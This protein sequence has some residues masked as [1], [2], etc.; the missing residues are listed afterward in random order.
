[1]LPCFLIAWTWAWAYL[2]HCLPRCGTN[3]QY[4]RKISL[5]PGNVSQMNGD[6]PGAE[7]P[8][9]SLIARLLPAMSATVGAGLLAAAIAACGSSASTSQNLPTT[10]GGGTGRTSTSLGASPGAAPVREGSAGAGAPASGKSATAKASRHPRKHS[11]A[12]PTK[13]VGGDSVPPLCA[14]LVTSQ[15]EPHPGVTA[16]PTPSSTP[17]PPSSSSTSPDG[18]P[19]PGP[20]PDP[21][22][23]PGP[24]PGPSA[25][26]GG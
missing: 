7:G 23:N 16:P 4:Y 10:A 13:G 20:D 18:A 8:A 25:E 14:S 24:T 26:A 15:S 17:S 21:A 5:N 3:R 12:C 1:M 6:Y 22:P 2:L 11:A 9:F 19:N